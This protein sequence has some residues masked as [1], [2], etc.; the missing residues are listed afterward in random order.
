VSE[1]GWVMLGREGPEPDPGTWEGRMSIRAR[2]RARQR[3]QAE[4]VVY[5]AEKTVRH[6]GDADC[7]HHY[8]GICD[9]CGQPISF[10]HDQC[11]GIID[12]GI[13]EAPTG[14]QLVFTWIRHVDGPQPGCDIYSSRV[15]SVERGD[16]E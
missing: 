5:E 15:Y 8:E 11:D 2:Q 16:G 12:I 9:V 1:Y 6:A 4:Q 7:I 10:T 3:K 13:E 14:E